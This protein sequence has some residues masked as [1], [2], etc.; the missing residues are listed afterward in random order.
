MTSSQSQSYLE[1][2]RKIR[3]VTNKQTAENGLEESRS[4]DE[5]MD[6]NETTQDESMVPKK[7]QKRDVSGE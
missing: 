7:K 4:V 3:Q 1:L 2:V 6:E 5:P